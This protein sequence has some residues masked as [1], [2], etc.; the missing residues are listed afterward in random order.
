MIKK[1]ILIGFN[2]ENGSFLIRQADGT[3]K[4]HS[5]GI[6]PLEVSESK[7]NQF[8][9][10]HDLIRLN[11]KFFS[12]P[13]V[14][15]YVNAQ[16]STFGQLFPAIENYTEDDI[17]E[18]L[19]ETDFITITRERKEA[20]KFLGDVLDKAPKSSITKRIEKEIKHRIKE[21]KR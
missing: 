6:T 9:A 3:L 5:I 1:I 18:T 15:R 17:R 4:F 16:M 19:D 10:E 12:F 11:K 20:S 7:L 2:R 21:L 13:A 14:R 8:M